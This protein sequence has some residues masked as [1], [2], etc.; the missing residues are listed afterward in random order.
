MLCLFG[1][2]GGEHL[3]HHDHYC[4]FSYSCRQ[5]QLLASGSINCLRA[6]MPVDYVTR[7]SI[8]EEIQGRAGATAATVA[9]GLKSPLASPLMAARVTSD[10]QMQR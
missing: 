9:A 7:S 8:G 1:D 2:S 3:H 10:T 5:L 6:V 4:F